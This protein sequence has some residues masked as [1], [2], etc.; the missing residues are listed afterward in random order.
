MIKKLI[1]ASIKITR[2]LNCAIAGLSIFLAGYLSNNYAINLP[3]MLLLSVA[4]IFVTAAGNIINDIFDIEIDK[5]NRPHRPLPSKILSLNFA[6]IFYSILV[7]LSVGISY[8]VNFYAFIIVIFSNTI[9][10]L[11][12][13]KLKSISLIGNFTVSFFTGLSFI[14]GGIAGNH[15]NLTYMP[16]FF[17]FLINFIREIVKDCEDLQGDKTLHL[18]TFPILFGYKTSIK[19]INS[20]IFILIFSCYF[21]IYTKKNIYV[22]LLITIVI[23]LLIFVIQFLRKNNFTLASKV[24]KICMLIGIISFVI[25]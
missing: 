6:K 15:I 23:I 19:L 5:I 17:A 7:F 1:F 25:K 11:Y 21:L 20:L 8:F 12:S 4:G 18:K 14:Y 13:Y 22:T 16:A 9:I 2:P 3:K 10:F 24:L